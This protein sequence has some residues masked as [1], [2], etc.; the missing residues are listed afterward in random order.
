MRVRSIAQTHP[1][2]TSGG[3]TPGLPE[4]D[5]QRPERDL[6][7]VDEQYAV[8]VDPTAN[9]SMPRAAGPYRTPSTLIPRRS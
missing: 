5:G 3:I 1:F 9:R 7:L 6:G 2:S 4:C 8:L